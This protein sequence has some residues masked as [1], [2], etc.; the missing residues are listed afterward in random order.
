[1]WRRQKGPHDNKSLPHTHTINTHAHSGWLPSW[2]DAITP[3]RVVLAR[4]AFLAQASVDSLLR[5]MEH[6]GEEE[7]EEEGWKAAV[8]PAPLSKLG[9]RELGVMGGFDVVVK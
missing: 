7:E 4:A 5:W 3:E 8:A 9:G 1:M 6:G 2:T